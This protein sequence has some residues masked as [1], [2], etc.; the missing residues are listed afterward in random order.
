MRRKREQDALDAAVGANP[1][2]R[3]REVEIDDGCQFEVTVE[4]TTGFVAPARS[5]H[6]QTRPS[7]SRLEA[8]PH[9]DAQPGATPVH[10]GPLEWFFASHRRPL[11]RPIDG[12]RIRH[13]NLGEWAPQHMRPLQT[14]Q[15]RRSRIEVDHFER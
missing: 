14:V 8:A 7:R 5:A 10:H 13:H 9:P 11:S 2:S 6:P 12:T 1:G 4:T 15:A 3:V